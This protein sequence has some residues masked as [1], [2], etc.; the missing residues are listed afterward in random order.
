MDRNTHRL[1]AR[2]ESLSATMTKRIDFAS[3]I[4]LKTINEKAGE[5]LSFGHRWAGSG[6]LVMSL[7]HLCFFLL[8]GAQ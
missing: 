5:V 7:L 1:A 8:L 2:K 3:H 6:V 4:S